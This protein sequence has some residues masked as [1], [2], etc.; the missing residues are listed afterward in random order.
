MSL[1]SLSPLVRRARHSHFLPLAAS[2][3][4]GG[5]AVVAV[6]YLLWPTWTVGRGSDPAS[7]PVT[8]GNTL[9]NVPT[10]AVRMRLQKR[11]GPQ[12]RVDLAIDELVAGPVLA[13]LD[14]DPPAEDAD[15]LDGVG[16]RDRLDG[17]DRL[18]AGELSHG[19]RLAFK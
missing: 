12:E 19:S 7:L 13:L 3:V 18:D 9:F 11:T 2:A 16:V 10:K 5:C 17:V 6:V 8:V 14:D 15:L 4:I 1:Y